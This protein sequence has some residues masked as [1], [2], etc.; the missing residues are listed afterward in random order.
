MDTLIIKP[1]S[2][3]NFDLLISLVKRLG[4][5]MNVVSDKVLS[6]ALF[7]AEIESAIKG[8]LLDKTEKAAFIKEIKRKVTHNQ[9]SKR[10]H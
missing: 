2:K 4:E 10:G 3:A 8:G 6:E 7:V 5:K 9:T 1:K